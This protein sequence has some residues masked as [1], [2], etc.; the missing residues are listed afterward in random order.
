MKV[1]SKLFFA[2]LI[3]AALLYTSCKK[4][5]VTAGKKTVDQ[6]IVSGK[7]AM[8]LYNALYGKLSGGQGIKTNGVTRLTTMG[9]N[10]TCGDVVVTP[11]NL[12]TH[13]GDTTSTYIGNSVF[14][15]QCDGYFNN[16]AIL[17]A[18]TLADTLAINETGSGFANYYRNTQNYVVKALDAQYSQVS[19]GGSITTMAR[20]SKFTSGSS[21]TPIDFYELSCQ[22]TLHNITTNR[23]SNT[24]EFVAGA[25]DFSSQQVDDVNGTPLALEGYILFLPD[26]I[27]EVNIRGTAGDK[28]Y[29]VDTLTGKVT[30]VR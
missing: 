13:S 21:G 1:T 4:S 22:Y 7:I 15:Y 3:G 12:T 30:T 25:V 16:S 2:T 5:D 9:V 26:H 14:T 8:S 11:T 23:T 24:A 27:L 28:L 29:D 19:V 18:Y 6:S 10:P 17:D 20:A